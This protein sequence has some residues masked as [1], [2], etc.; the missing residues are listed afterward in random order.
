L[1]LGRYRRCVLG[2]NL[3]A[4]ETHDVVALHLFVWRAVIQRDAYLS[5]MAWR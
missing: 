3:V 2:Y 1:Q 4:A 5:D